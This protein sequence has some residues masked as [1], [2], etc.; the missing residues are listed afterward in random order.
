MAD[1]TKLNG[2]AIQD[3]YLPTESASKLVGYA[4]SGTSDTAV[5]ITK[6]DAY[7]ITIS[8]PSTARPFVFVA[9]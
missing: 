5:T 6:L 3:A 4:I 1:V 7:V 8:A 9:T 2:Y